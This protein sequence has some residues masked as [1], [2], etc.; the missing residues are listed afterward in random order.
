MLALPAEIG[1]DLAVADCSYPWADGDRTLVDD[2]L[3][4]AGV[5]VPTLLLNDAELAAVTVQEQEPVCTTLVLTVGTGVGAALV[6][7]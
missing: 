7:R 2:V 1:D 6:V 4:S 5:D 3:T